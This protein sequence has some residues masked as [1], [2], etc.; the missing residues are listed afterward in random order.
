MR[1]RHGNGPGEWEVGPP[2]RNPVVQG[3]RSEDG[4]KGKCDLFFRLDWNW[5]RVLP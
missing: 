3:A 2:H 5:R 1:R 4:I